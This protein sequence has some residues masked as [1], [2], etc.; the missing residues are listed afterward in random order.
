MTYCSLQCI[1]FCIKSSIRKNKCSDRSRSMAVKL[2][3]RTGN[4]DRQTNRQADRP[5]D[6]TTDGHFITQKM[7]GQSSVFFCF[8][9]HWYIRKE[10]YLTS[11][12]TFLSRSAQINHN[13]WL[14]KDYGTSRNI[15][16][17]TNVFDN[18]N[19]KLKGSCSLIKVKP[20]VIGFLIPGRRNCRALLLWILRRFE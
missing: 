9:S 13:S 7:V 14:R 5:T 15:I 1:N 16:I 10:K 3:S 12:T 8:T 6:Q 19:A 18:C 20:N 17:I 2:T 4:Y 11:W